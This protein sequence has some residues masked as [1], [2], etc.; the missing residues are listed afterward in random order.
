M[1][2]LGKDRS[3]EE[4]GTS[5]LSRAQQNTR[6]QRRRDRRSDRNA[7]LALLGGQLVGGIFK[8]KFDNDF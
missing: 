1:I 7:I 5:L 8:N 4:F 2:D 6:R 3:I